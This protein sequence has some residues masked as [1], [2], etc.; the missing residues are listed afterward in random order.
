MNSSL[1]EL[2]HAKRE[3]IVPTTEQLE[4]V[5]SIYYSH[6][7]P[8]VF[9]NSKTSRVYLHLRGKVSK[10]LF[11]RDVLF[12]DLLQIDSFCWSGVFL[13][14]H[15]LSSHYCNW[16]WAKLGIHVIVYRFRKSG[17][18]TVFFI[19]EAECW[20]SKSFEKSHLCHHCK[21]K[22]SFGYLHW[23]VSFFR[24]RYQVS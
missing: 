18:G 8:M 10:A 23:S 7:S 16:T 4:H 5:Q 15:M 21:K 24:K 17:H 2:K 22:L 9:I 3:G 12:L 14:I 1:Q 20:I 19:R 6:A 13:R 11:S